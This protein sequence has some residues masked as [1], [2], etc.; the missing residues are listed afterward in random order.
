MFTKPPTFEPP[1]VP[2]NETPF[3][4]RL[5]EAEEHGWVFNWTDAGCHV[6]PPS[7]WHP[8]VDS[9]EEILNQFNL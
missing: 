7:E 2:E 8:W 6:T 1:P 4:K 3:Q 9:R 5:R